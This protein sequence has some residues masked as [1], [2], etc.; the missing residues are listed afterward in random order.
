MPR[1]RQSVNKQPYSADKIQITIRFAANLY[2]S[3][4]LYRPESRFSGTQDVTWLLL[5]MPDFPAV[6]S[7]LTANLSPASWFSHYFTP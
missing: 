6:M 5:A 2:L 1:C 7:F 4:G 3:T